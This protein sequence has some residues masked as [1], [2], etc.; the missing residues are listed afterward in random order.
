M[1]G[2]RASALNAER[3]VR[4]ERDLRDQMFDTSRHMPFAHSVARR[5]REIHRA[6]RFALARC[7]ALQRFF[8]RQPLLHASPRPPLTSACA[9]RGRN[10][11]PR[12]R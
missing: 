1:N 8:A 11:N 12:Y 10:G 7:G 9:S 6:A 2:S 5:C 4:R 3:L